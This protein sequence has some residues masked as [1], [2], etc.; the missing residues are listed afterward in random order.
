M[1]PLSVIAILL[2]L[3]FFGVAAVF[4]S[5]GL[6]DDTLAAVAATLIGGILLI[7]GIAGIQ[8]R[9]R[10]GDTETKKTV[11]SRTALAAVNSSLGIGRELAILLRTLIHIISIDDRPKS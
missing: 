10:K 2:A 3:T 6:T 7:A 4:Q 8:S 5:R 1:L 11:I 9:H